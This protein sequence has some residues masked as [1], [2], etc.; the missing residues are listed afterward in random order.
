MPEFLFN[1]VAGLEPE[2]LFM[3]KKR[4]STSFYLWILVKFFRRPIFVENLQ[5]AAFGDAFLKTLWTTASTF[6][7]I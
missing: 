2:I 5:G 6:P 7:R 4:F 1:K 3:L